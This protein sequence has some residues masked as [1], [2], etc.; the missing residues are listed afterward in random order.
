VRIDRS[1]EVSVIAPVRRLLNQL[2]QSIPNLTV[3]D[4]FNS[5][6]PPIQNQCSTHSGQQMLFS[7]SNHLTNEGARHVSAAFLRFLGRKPS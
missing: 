7:D 3:F 6:C 2:D 1:A 5:L 4:P